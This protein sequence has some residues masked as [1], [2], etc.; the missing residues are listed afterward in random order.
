MFQEYDV[1]QVVY[2]APGKHVQ[3]SDY[4]FRPP[5]V[6][7]VGTIVL[8]AT[9]NDKTGYFVECLADRAVT[10]WI[11]DFSAEEL[12]SIPA[13]TPNKFRATYGPDAREVA[14]R[15]FEYY[16]RIRV[17]ATAEAMLAG[18]LGII[19]GSR[20]LAH[21]QRDVTPID[22]DP[23]FRIFVGIQ[24]E[25]DALPLG[26]QRKFWHPAALQIQDQEIS[27]AEARF[28]ESALNGCR[29]LIARFK[30]VDDSLA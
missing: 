10:I 6:G 8:I 25:T 26:N 7:D 9:A 20:Q 5:L 27:K 18:E 30:T 15:A 23:D 14:Q 1:V 16:Q 12:A 19:A 24:S 28:R 4:F 22:L 17:V 2:L 11:D 13:C 29:V 3:G 21:L